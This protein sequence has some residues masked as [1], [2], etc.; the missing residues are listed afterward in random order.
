MKIGAI[1]EVSEGKK[2][3]ETSGEKDRKRVIAQPGG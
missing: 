3:G 2:D 1:A